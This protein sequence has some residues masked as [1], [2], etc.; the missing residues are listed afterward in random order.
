MKEPVG[1][2]NEVSLIGLVPLSD[3]DVN[4]L[5]EAMRGKALAT[6]QRI[7]VSERL[8]GRSLTCKQAGLLLQTIKLGLMQ[9]IL[10]F[11]VLQGRLS[12]LPDG[13]NHVLEPLAGPQLRKDVK[14]GLQSPEPTRV[15]F[16]D[17]HDNEK[18]MAKTFCHSTSMPVSTGEDST[19]LVTPLSP[20]YCDSRHSLPLDNR[21]PGWEHSVD[22]LRARVKNGDVAPELHEDLAH[23]FEALGLGPLP[24]SREFAVQRSATVGHLSSAQSDPSHNTSD[25]L[26]ELTLPGAPIRPQS[27]KSQVSEESV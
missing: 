11:E 12:D 15:S 20:T 14:A 23:V 18:L 8:A 19:S 25:I 13:L 27:A 7:L 21:K 22:R 16:L 5:A 26:Q 17:K 10:A 3:A 6:D 9:R 4:D 1:D 2:S 24:P